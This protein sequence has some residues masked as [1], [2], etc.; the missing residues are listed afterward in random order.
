ME[1]VEP[2][3]APKDLRAGRLLT[4]RVREMFRVYPKALVG[5]VEA[6][7]DLRVAARRLR[8]ALGLLAENPEGRRARR[9]DKTLRDLARAAGRG[10]DLDVGV[11]ILEGLPA[12]ASEGNVR[13]RRALSA[14]RSRARF[15][16]REALLD[17]E[18]A[19]LRRDLRALVAATRV[20]RPVLAGRL[21]ALRLREQSNI[22]RDL[23]TGRAR[24]K[25]EQLHSA[26]RAARRL[27]YAAEVEALFDGAESDSAERFRKMQ[28]RL[29]DIQ[30]RHVLSAWLAHRQQRAAAR[31]DLALASAAARAL[32]RVKR[33]AARLTGEFV[34]ARAEAG[35]SGSSLPS[36]G[37]P[38]SAR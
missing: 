9:A 18:L 3:V 17:L 36:L 4:R 30:D 8:A 20:D 13:L 25:P 33:D 1:S 12:A 10:R 21:D 37:D 26:R 11:E 16:S 19:H 5:E 24:P 34:R 2:T 29:G 14:S 6:V 7:H 15:L 32:S 23:S 27:R 22:D 28:S 31:G 38:T 35:H